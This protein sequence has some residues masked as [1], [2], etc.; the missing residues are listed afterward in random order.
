MSFIGNG[1]VFVKAPNAM[2]INGVNYQKDEVVCYFHNAEFAIGFAIDLTKS[3]NST[4][5]LLSHNTKNAQ[6]VQIKVA[7]LKTGVWR[8]IG[9]EID[10]SNAA[11]PAAKK[12]IS[13]SNGEA[14][15]PA[16]GAVTTLAISNFET[17]Q[18]E[19]GFTFTSEGHITGLPADEVFIAMYSEILDLKIAHKITTDS[20]PYLSLE[21]VQENQ[22]GTVLIKIPKVSLST[23]P[24]FTFNSETMV[25][26]PIN[27]I[28]VNSEVEIYEYEW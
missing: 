25:S 27:F 20:I 6:Q 7:G 8:L 15:L 23:S 19:S 1:E 18:K 22:D 14:F 17:M 28:I 5:I 3:N 16:S 10:A 11:K 2:K 21:F 13:D 4:N 24:D 26:I 9:K 12:I